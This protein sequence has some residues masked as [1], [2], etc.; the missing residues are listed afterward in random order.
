MKQSQNEYKKIV[1][2]YGN[3]YLA[4]KQVNLCFTCIRWGIDG[5]ELKRMPVS[6]SEEYCTDREDKGKEHPE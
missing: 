2:K 1:E 4:G 5:C 6:I 3:R